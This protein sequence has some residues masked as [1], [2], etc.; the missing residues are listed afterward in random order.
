MSIWWSRWQF[1]LAEIQCRGIWEKRQGSEHKYELE[2]HDGQVI[3]QC[4]E[5]EVWIE[6]LQK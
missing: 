1:N 2:P 6:Q 5:E 3:S 4:K